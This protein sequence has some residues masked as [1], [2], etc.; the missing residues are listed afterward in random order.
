VK[1]FI[2]FPTKQ[3][4][5]HSNLNRGNPPIN[6][7]KH[8]TKLLNFSSLWQLSNIQFFS[9]FRPE[10]LNNIKDDHFRKTG[11]LPN[12]EYLQQLKQIHPKNEKCLGGFSRDR[13][14]KPV[15]SQ[16]F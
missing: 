13:I 7:P 1:N 3:L 4:L 8:L 6:D 9:K 5:Y 2:K 10:I 12:K 14:F 16:I 15:L 11:F